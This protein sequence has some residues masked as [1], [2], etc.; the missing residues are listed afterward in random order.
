MCFDPNNIRRYSDMDA[1]KKIV[2]SI[3][4][5]GFNGYYTRKLKG[6]I[7]GGHFHSE[8]FLCDP[9]SFLSHVTSY[10]T[11]TPEKFTIDWIIET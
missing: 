3:C 4:G 10:D 1:D 2:G 7:H 9:K 8:V 11:R 6:M 5:L